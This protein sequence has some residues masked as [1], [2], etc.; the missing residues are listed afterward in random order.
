[1]ENEKRF[2][3]LPEHADEWT[4][5]ANPEDWIVDLPEIQRLAAEWDTTEA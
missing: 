5:S 4:N 2:R 1:M 3:I